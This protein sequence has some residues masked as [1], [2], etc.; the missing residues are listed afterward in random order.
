MKRLLAIITFLFIS[1]YTQSMDIK[2]IDKKIKNLE[3]KIYANEIRIKNNYFTDK[4][5]AIRANNLFNME[6]LKETNKGLKQQ[7]LLLI[8]ERMH[9]QEANTF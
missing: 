7:V 6:R 8:E 1:Q 4:D 2:Q 5:G 3:T 9:L